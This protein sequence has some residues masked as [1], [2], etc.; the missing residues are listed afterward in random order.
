MVEQ[1][2]VGVWKASSG[3]RV[4]WFKDPDGSLLSSA[5]RRVA[6]VA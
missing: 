5:G 6:V 2:D 1:D 3:A 4:A